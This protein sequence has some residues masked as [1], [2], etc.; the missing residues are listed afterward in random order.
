MKRTYKT[1]AILLCLNVSLLFGCSSVSPDGSGE[2]MKASDTLSEV[3]EQTGKIAENNVT[4]EAETDEAVTE[5][6]VTEKPAVK[7]AETTTFSEE[8]L[9]EKRILRST[10][11]CN[12]SYFRMCGICGHQY[13]YIQIESSDYL[14][15][16]QI[17]KLNSDLDILTD[18]GFP[19]R[20]DRSHNPGS[21]ADLLPSPHV[22]DSES[23]PYENWKNYGLNLWITEHHDGGSMTCFD[24]ETY[25]QLTWDDILGENWMDHCEKSD[26]S[27][28]PVKINGYIYNDLVNKCINVSFIG[29]PESDKY[30]YTGVYGSIPWEDV[31]QKYITPPEGWDE[32]REK[33]L[34][35]NKINRY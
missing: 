21:H 29:Y 5:T 18:N 4:E 6:V 3:S 31:N 35:D 13:E 34:E 14:T 25:E 22:R 15:D 32:I 1:A 11:I 26:E 2:N 33:I 20:E 30:E 7:K 9:K 27:I 17:N 12:Y 8:Q 10:D 16:E 23:D 19:G 24:P 28:V